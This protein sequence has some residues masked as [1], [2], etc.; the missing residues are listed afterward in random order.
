M[1]G[2]QAVLNGYAVG[3]GWGFE[4]FFEKVVWYALCFWKVYAGDV[5]WVVGGIIHC[6]REEDCMSKHCHRLGF[7]CSRL[8]LLASL[9][10]V[11]VFFPYSR[12][13]QCK[14]ADVS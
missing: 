10:S 6:F 5:V 8:L 14:V 13:Y 1:V 9:M 12:S 3:M 2:C 11:A 7:C 4:V